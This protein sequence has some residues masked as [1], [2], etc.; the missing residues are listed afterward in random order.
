MYEYVWIC[1]NHVWICVKKSGNYLPAITCHWCVTLWLWKKHS[2][3]QSVMSCCTWNWGRRKVAQKEDTEMPVVWMCW[4]CNQCLGTR[5]VPKHLRSSSATLLRLSGCLIMINGFGDLWRDGLWN[6]NS[7]IFKYI[8]IDIENTETND[9]GSDCRNSII[10][11]K[12]YIAGRI[13]IEVIDRHR[14]RLSWNCHKWN[15]N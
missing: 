1:L 6:W 8:Q 2:Q 12:F 7:N 15:C 5:S 10:S 3:S 9:W 14:S 4:W 11:L 13:R